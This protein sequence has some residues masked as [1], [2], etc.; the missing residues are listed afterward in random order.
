MKKSYLFLLIT[1]K[2]LSLRHEKNLS[3]NS[4]NL[5]LDIDMNPLTQEK[6]QRATAT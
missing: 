5:R 6:L 3:Y 1:K 4:D 2:A